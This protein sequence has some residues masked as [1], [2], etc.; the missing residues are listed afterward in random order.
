MKKI[1]TLIIFTILLTS[2]WSNNENSNMSQGNIQKSEIL[3]RDNISD[4]IEKEGK[5][6]EKNKRDISRVSDLLKIKY[7]IENFYSDY[8][9][10][11]NTKEFRKILINYINSN[12]NG[13]VSDFFE[14]VMNNNIPKDPKK[15]VIIDWCKFG[16]I[17]KV[18]SYFWIKNQLYTLSTCLENTNLSILNS[19]WWSDDKRYQIWNLHN[20]DFD[21][22]I[23][24]N[25]SDT[26]D[27]IVNKTEQWVYESYSN[28][29]NDKTNILFIKQYYQDLWEWKIK[30]V[31]YKTSWETWRKTFETF[32]WWYKWINKTKIN[33]IKNLW[34]NKY[35]INV[36]LFY[37]WKG[38]PENYIVIKKIVLEG[39][40]R[41]LETL[42]K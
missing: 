40:K 26:L 18:W 24:I 30:D 12:E 31:Y 25:D 7:I 8:A 22:K 29:L 17:Y 32:S 19:D 33:S 41:I 6:N 16:Y 34:N 1:I 10:Y 35:K 27:K 2:C 42:K 36:D 37:D 14:K 11:P 38:K 20:N 13:D 39:N 15:G 23:Y 5:N 3:I 28:N 4:L 21:S 9:E